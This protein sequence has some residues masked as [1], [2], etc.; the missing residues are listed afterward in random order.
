MYASPPPCHSDTVCDL[1]G[2]S[3]LA[4]YGEYSGA[5]SES[6]TYDYA[7]TL[8]GLMTEERHPRGSYPLYIYLKTEIYM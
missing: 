3:E 2:S 5:P 8:L 4:N 1:G 6:Q 7:K